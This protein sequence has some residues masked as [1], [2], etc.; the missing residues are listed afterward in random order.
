MSKNGNKKAE[1]SLKEGDSMNEK[2]DLFDLATDG[3]T[4]A[5]RKP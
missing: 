2:Q 1:R 5:G 3:G 4:D